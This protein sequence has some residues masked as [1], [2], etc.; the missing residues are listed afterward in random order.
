MEPATFFGTPIVRS[1]LLPPPLPESFSPRPRV[2]AALADRR[3]PVC[4]VQ[5]PA[6]YGKTVAVAEALTV[7]PP[8]AAAWLGID[9]YDSRELAFWAHLVAAVDRVR[10][11]I[12]Q[13]V[14]DA[15]SRVAVPAGE[16][17]VSSLLA[18][19]DGVDDLVLVLDDIHRLHE[20]CVWQQLSY[21]LDR[22]PP[23]VHVVATTRTV[24]PLP[25][26]RWLS[27][28]RAVV[29]DERTL[30]FDRDE[31]VRLI[32]GI[33]GTEVT[34]H[35]VT[36]L[37]ASSEGWVVGLLFEALALRGDPD[38][39]GWDPRSSNSPR[40]SRSVIN[41][42]TTEVLANLSPDDQEFLLSISVLDEFDD[43]LCRRVTGEGD[44]GLRLRALRVAN[45]FMVPVDETAGRFRFHHLFRELLLEELERRNPGRLV[46]LHR[47]GA[48]A[49]A[50]VGDV[51]AQIH[52]LLAAGDEQDAFDLLVRY[53]LD[54]GSLATARALI[55]EFPTGFVLAD[56]GRMLDFVLVLEVAGDFTAAEQWCD[57]A[58]VA[59][60]RPDSPLRGRL[61]LHR[62]INFAGR[63]E[64]GLALE[65]MEACLAARA[66]EP[67]ADGTLARLPAPLAARTQ[68]LLTRDA[69]AAE[70]WL[71]EARRLPPEIF[72]VHQLTIPA[73]TAYLLVRS[74]DLEGAERE[75]RGVL[76]AAEDHRV[77]PGLS[78]LEALLTLAD[79]CLETARIDEAGH[80]LHQ[81][82]KVAGPLAPV[83]YH[84]LAALL[85]IDV[86]AATEGPGAG[87]DE[88]TRALAAFHRQRVSTGLIDQLAAS[89]ARWLLVAGNTS[90]AVRVISSLPPSPEASLL[91]ARLAVLTHRV[92]V[93]ERE[94]ADRADWFA[95]EL[96][97]ADL[98]TSSAH[99]FRHA[100]DVLDRH[101][102]YLWTAVRQGQP[103]LRHLA[104]RADA[105]VAGCGPGP[106][107]RHLL[108]L[109]VPPGR[110]W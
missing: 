66:R 16:E 90:E 95:S 82:E 59:L 67:G 4:M 96:L 55:A 13:A 103:L 45:L 8:E 58:A 44:A 26:E 74:G 47:R 76:T 23:G 24:T 110:C 81:A 41:Y 80:Y 34:A 40:S 98:V 64:A 70:T 105:S 57:R 29:V 92:D 50:A 93:V 20:P 25:V 6:G 17:V 53:A 27:Q 108:P 39:P 11:G 85:R 1:K 37:V 84:V 21:F 104:D 101:P 77:P 75:A 10:P 99:G 2:V 88:A 14:V 18:V 51:P 91:R 63:G 61:E 62:A 106:R 32:G 12:L 97:E 42:L 22:L 28:D 56:P 94:L 31:A 60:D 107:R 86:T 5:A 83:T 7:A 19:L 46:E 9:A 109:L 72:H 30:R 102:A 35:Q 65:A 73:L 68:V 3:R 78:A 49:T 52:H 71:D 79:V 48:S 54:A 38:E 89:R 33:W 100:E 43:D 15:N 36:R 69:G 87:V